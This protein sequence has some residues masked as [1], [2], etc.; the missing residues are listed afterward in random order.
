MA[1]VTPIER[2]AARL[3]VSDA[4]RIEKKAVSAALII[5]SR[6]QG[7]VLREFRSGGDCVGCI[8]EVLE[9]AKSLIL[10]TLVASYLAAIKRTRRFAGKPVSVKPVE[11]QLEDVISPLVDAIQLTPE[12][13]LDIAEVFGSQTD[14]V[15]EAMTQSI[16]GSVNK[17]VAEVEGLPRKKQIAAIQKKF[18]NIGITPANP[19]MLEGVFRTQAQFASSAGQF[20]ALRDPDIEEILWGFKY[21]TVGDDRV[22][23]EHAALEGVTLPKNAEEWNTIYPPNGWNCRCSVIPIFAPRDQVDL[24]EDFSVSG[25]DESFRFNPGKIFVPTPISG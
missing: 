15:L 11:F 23:P 6:L 16:Q 1:R 4:Q 5:S 20:N 25:I 7:R 18:K 14:E 9:D 22:R 12:Q 8:R 21:V 2:K 17:V 3:I 24:P 10:E 13:V 19:S